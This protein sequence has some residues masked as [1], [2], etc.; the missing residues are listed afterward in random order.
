MNKKIIIGACA[1]LGAGIIYTAAALNPVLNREAFTASGDNPYA[2]TWADGYGVS[3]LKPFP[4]AIAA[5]SEQI[6]LMENAAA[7][8][9]ASV[10]EV[11]ASAEPTASAAP[12]AA[13]KTSSQAVSKTASKAA[14]QATASKSAS[15]TPSKAASQAAPKAAST[16]K[17]SSAPSKTSSP[18]SAE[19]GGLAGKVISTAKKYLGVPYVWG[20]AT[21]SGFDCSGFIQYIYAQHGITLPR[22]TAEQYGAGASIAKASLKPGDLVFFETYKAGPSHVGIYLGDNQ[23]IHASSG[24]GKVMVSNLTSSYY[25]EHYIGSI[26]VIN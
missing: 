7:P 13:A 3:D 14:G 12:K 16:S 5:Q 22:T 4:L 18:S 20:G 2:I 25:T 23:F 26:R 17:A 9:T 11:Q 6:M 15:T 24:S 1:L 8:A 10:A 19:T 21:P